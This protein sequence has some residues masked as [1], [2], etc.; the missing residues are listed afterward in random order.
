MIV[1]F[2]RHWT[3]CSLI[4]ALL[5]LSACRQPSH[6]EPH[7]KQ[8]PEPLP[9]DPQIRVYFNQNQSRGADYTEPYRQITRPGDDL[10]QAIIERINSAQT[11]I[12]VAV[13]EFRLPNI[14]L[15]LASRHRAGV[16]VRVIIE[17]SYNRPWSSYTEAELAR[18]EDRDIRAFEEARTLIDLNGDGQLTAEEINQRDAL[19]I[20]ANANIPLIDDTEDG[21]KGS[22]LMHHKFIVIDGKTTLVASANFTTSGVHGDFLA[23]DTR[24]NANNL[25]VI[26]SPELA[27]RFQ[28]EFALMW[29]DGPGGATDSLFGVRKPPRTYRPLQIGNSAIAVHFS[30]NSPSQD[31]NRSSNGLIG[32]ALKSA[33][34]SIDLA[35]L[36]FSE[37]QLVNIIRDRHSDGV[38][39]RVLI[40]PSFAF[41]S[42]SEG[43][44]MLGVA[45]ASQCKYEIDNAPWTTPV[46]S[47]GVPQ[48]PKG[49]KLHHKFGIVDEEIVIAGSHNWSA[50][51]NHNN[52]ETVI[53][54]RNPAIAAHFHREM[55]RLY[56]RA[57]LGLPPRISEKIQTQQQECGEIATPSSLVIPA[58]VNINTASPAELET[59]P[60]VGPKLAQRIVETRQQQ[61][62]TSLDD[63]QRVPGIGATM[64]Q[65]LQ[66]RVSW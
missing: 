50:A 37:Q 25:L 39:V 5:C 16:A 8:R 14:A 47:V 29:G 40:D 11:S 63:L 48:I 28:E 30:P 13:Q 9:Q 17:N 55:N 26:E 57:I 56:S 41:R 12:E 2:R 52:D 34:E 53:V 66:G 43:L 51:A 54:I 22:S 42:Y 24:G 65:K 21:S 31:W 6:L 38:D 3:F 36:V 23:P 33:S 58:I 7:L 10:E 46:A 44:D 20:L 19:V 49:D 1:Q 59:L 45:L 18:L 4:F 62:F 32:A 64:V 15:A 61:P 27:R 35:L 60:G